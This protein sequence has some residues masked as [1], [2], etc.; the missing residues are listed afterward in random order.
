MSRSRGAILL[1]TFSPIAIDP[2]V[3]DSRPAS[4]RSAV[5]LPEPDGPTSTMNSPS[6]ISRSSASTA[7]ESLPG[8]IRVAFSNRTSAMDLAPRDA[9]NRLAQL[10]PGTLLRLRPRPQIVERE[11]RRADDRRRGRR[12][13][14]QARQPGGDPVEQPPVGALEHPAA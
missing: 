13:Q 6:P 5:V 11:Q 7:G 12:S 14:L 1:T 2:V 10:P 8:Y 3:T 9:R 4:M